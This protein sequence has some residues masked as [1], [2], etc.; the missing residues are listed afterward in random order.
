MTDYWR[1]HAEI[2][3]DEAG[4][5]ATEKQLETIAGVIESAHDFFSQSM[6]HDVASANW[7]GSKEREIADLNKELHAEREKV[8]CPECKGAGTLTGYGPCH[9]ATSDCWKCHGNGRL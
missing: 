8:V 2:A 4:L 5:E 7:H 9:S 6:G 1:E 3:M